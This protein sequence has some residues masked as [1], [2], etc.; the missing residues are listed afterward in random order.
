[1][2]IDD[3]TDVQNVEEKIFSSVLLSINQFK[4]ERIDSIV[5][6]IESCLQPKIKPYRNEK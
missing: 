1:M 2:N 3:E 6:Y 4:N 5:T